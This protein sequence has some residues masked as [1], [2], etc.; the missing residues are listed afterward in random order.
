[1]QK[2]LEDAT[3]IPTSDWLDVGPRYPGAILAGKE[4]ADKLAALFT[5]RLRS[6]LP[7]MELALEGIRTK[8][9]QQVPV[10]AGKICAQTHVSA[11]LVRGADRFSL[12]VRLPHTSG[13]ETSS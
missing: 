12:P 9:R 6:K 3:S 8:A 11:A 13:R 7:A 1:M 4:D 10:S 2:I 5:G